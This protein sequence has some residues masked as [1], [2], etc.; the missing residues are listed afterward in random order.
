MRVP[1][2]W[3]GCERT[4]GCSGGPL[5]LARAYGWARTE[6][7]RSEGRARTCGPARARASTAA[8]TRAHRPGRHTAGPEHGHLARA[9]VDASARGAPGSTWRECVSTATREA[10]LARC[11]ANRSGAG[12]RA[13][14][15]GYDGSPMAG[16]VVVILAAGHGTRMKSRTPK[17]LHDLCGKPL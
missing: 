8:M 9:H 3:T 11:G 16:P 17:V 5:T 13:L 14:G 1:H 15:W 12:G 6:A 2:Q 10:F 4:G 7:A